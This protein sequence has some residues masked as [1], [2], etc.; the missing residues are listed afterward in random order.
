MMVREHILQP[1]VDGL[2]FAEAPRWHAGALW[3]SDIARHEVLR[4][5][6][7]SAAV[8][9][10][11]TTPGEPSGLGWLPDGSLLV[12]QMEEHTV[13]RGRPAVGAMAPSYGTTRGSAPCA[14][15]DHRPGSGGVLALYAQTGAFSRGKLNDMVVG[16]DGRAW[17]S[18]MG[19]DYET[20]TARSTTL[21]A[22]DPQGVA[23]AAA[24]E[25]WCPNGMAIAPSGRQ[26]VVGQSASR[27]VLEFDIDSKANLGERRV[28]G[29]LPEGACSDGLCM[30][31]AGA[32][33]IASPTTREFLRM[34]RGGRIS[35]RVPTRERHAIACV[36]GGEDRR[37]LFCLTSSTLS[38]RAAR[39]TAEGR[40]GTV[41]VDVAGAGTP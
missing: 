18:N 3:V 5:D 38:L 4:I 25:L 29:T 32:L 40:V 36:L 11:F 7:C 2:G 6:V 28:F 9:R 14:R 23:Y 17:L 21:V 26:L 12:V 33:W 19:F 39:G 27:E 1:L 22:L 35:D 24:T 10:V 8:E 20:E 41:R 15:R 16:A 31:A 13:L 30:D 34:E 37:T